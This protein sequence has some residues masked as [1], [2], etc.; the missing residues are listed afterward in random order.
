LEKKHSILKLICGETIEKQENEKITGCQ[1]SKKVKI[2]ILE[3]LLKCG[4]DFKL[5]AA[6]QPNRFRSDRLIKNKIIANE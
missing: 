1:L 2:C 3:H 5:L 6:V 4:T